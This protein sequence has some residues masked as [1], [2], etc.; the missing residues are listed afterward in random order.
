M[1]LPWRNW[2]HLMASTFGQ[3]L[4]GDDR[5]FRTRHHREHVE[6]DYKSPP[7]ERKYE[8]RHAH[9][10]KS[11]KRPTVWL[12]EAAREKACREIAG[13]LKQ[14]GI[15]FIDLCVTATHLHLMARF[16]SS[17]EVADMEGNP[18]TGVGGLSWE[19]LKSA[20]E[21]AAGW[22]IDDDDDVNHPAPHALHSPPPR[23]AGRLA[24]PVFAPGEARGSGAVSR[25]IVG[26]ARQGRA[27]SGSVACD[28]HR[29]VHP[30]TC[31]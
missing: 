10:K 15:E 27:G 13:A 11:M 12:P 4:P 14:Y 30:R 21:S 31:G 28:S 6:G 5:G 19:V 29:A 18:P 9:V 2:Y 7:P 25:R 20:V 16:D 17:S 8:A 22:F 3:W 26:Q 24:P 23:P 1:K